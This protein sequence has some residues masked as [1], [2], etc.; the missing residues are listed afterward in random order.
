MLTEKISEVSARSQPNSST[1]ATKKTVKESRTP[2][3][4]NSVRLETATMVQ[5]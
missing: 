4:T 1:R 2:K 5:P 3:A